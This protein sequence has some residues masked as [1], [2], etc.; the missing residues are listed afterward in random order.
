MGI[1]LCSNL[2]TKLILWRNPQGHER[3]WF[4]RERE[5]RVFPSKGKLLLAELG[6]GCLGIAST[7]E[8]IVS[9]IVALLAKLCCSRSLANRAVNWYRS[10]AFTTLWAFSNLFFNFV[11]PNLFTEERNAN[12]WAQFLQRLPIQ[13]RN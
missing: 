11:Y 4:N 12:T 7:V 5:F 3:I 8:W 6:F 1:S 9:A 2:T 13:R 10:S